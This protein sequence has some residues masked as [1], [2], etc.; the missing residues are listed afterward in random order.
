M[1]SSG[2]GEVKVEGMNS[3]KYQ[4]SQTLQ[5]SVRKQKMKTNLNFQHDNDPKHTSK[6]TKQWLKKS[7]ETAAPEPIPD[8]VWGDL[9]WCPNNDTEE[10]EELA[11]ITMARCAKLLASNRKSAVIKSNIIFGLFFRFQ[12]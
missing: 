2:F 11:N 4:L 3:Y 9:W 8:N 7:F 1:T 5:A 6:S 10:D 12:L